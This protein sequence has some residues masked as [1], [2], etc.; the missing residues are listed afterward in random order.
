VEPD[1]PGAADP[2]AAARA[3]AEWNGRWLAGLFELNALA[4]AGW[5]QWQQAGWQQA[6]AALDQLPLWANWQF[7]TE[8]LA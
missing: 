1:D 3:W 5:L 8:Q 2:A 4:W 7:G 6:R